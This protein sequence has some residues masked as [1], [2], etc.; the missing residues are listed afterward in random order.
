MLGDTGHDGA[1]AGSDTGFGRLYHFVKRRDPVGEVGIG[2]LFI[3]CWPW[4]ARLPQLAS[5]LPRRLGWQ[6]REAADFANRSTARAARTIMGRKFG[7]GV[8][9]PVAL[10]LY[11]LSR[12]TARGARTIMAR[13]LGIGV[14]LAVTLRLYFR[15]SRVRPTT[16]SVRPDLG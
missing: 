9:L 3:G 7:T 14:L 16:E 8:L 12:S 4:Q 13:K 5:P 2:C 15:S 11:F 10:W 1:P 6:R